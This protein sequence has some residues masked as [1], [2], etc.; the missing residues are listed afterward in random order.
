MKIVKCRKCGKTYETATNRAGLCP[1]CRKTRS[2]INTKYRDENYDT[3]S[4]YI[5][6]GSKN[7]LKEFAKSNGLSLNQLCNHALEKY[8]DELVA[9]KDKDGQ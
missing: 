1:D 6:K 3:V 5:S 4:F 7:Q 9:K 8:I 2:Q